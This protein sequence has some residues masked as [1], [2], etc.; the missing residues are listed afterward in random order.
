[1][2]LQLDDDGAALPLVRH[3]PRGLGRRGAEHVGERH[4]EQG[5]RVFIAQ[6]GG[7]PS[8]NEAAILSRHGPG[9]ADDSVTLDV[10]PGPSSD[11]A[12]FVVKC[13]T[14]LACPT[15]PGPN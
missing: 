11:G 13:P 4:G 6:L 7:N 1:M 10:T 15:V 14:A 2:T 9:G 8:D 5:E 12:G 3:R